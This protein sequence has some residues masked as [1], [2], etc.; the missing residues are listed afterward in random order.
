[1]KEVL[2]TETS[3]QIAHTMEV[4]YILAHKIAQKEKVSWSSARDEH[5]G[6][7]L[8]ILSKMDGDI[9]FRNNLI[10]VKNLYNHLQGN[11]NQIES[12]GR[13]D[14]YIPQSMEILKEMYDMIVELIP[15]KGVKVA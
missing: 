13:L 15:N 11:H 8:D 6:A 2:L 3:N 7:L 12:G 9:N 14:Y 10:K 4:I 1:M 5:I